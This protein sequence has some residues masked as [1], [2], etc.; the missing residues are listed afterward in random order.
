MKILITND[1]GISSPG[2]FAAK[3]AMESRGEVAVIAPD[4]N[5]SAIGRG[6]TIGRSLRVVET[7]FPDGSSGFAV[8]GTPVDCVR[9]AAL[10]FLQWHPDI[11]ISGIN[12]GPN[13]GDDIT[14]SGT[15]AA[16]FEGVML[17]IPA[18]AISI[19][20]GD[21]Y[22]FEPVARFTAGIAGMIRQNH[23]P[24]VILLNINSPNLPA[25]ELQGAEVT[26]LGKRIYRDQLVEE[27]AADGDGGGRSYTIYGDDPSYHEEDGTDFHA[28][29]QRKISVTPIHFALTNLT[30]MEII[31]NWD[32]DRLAREA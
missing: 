18:I 22:N 12:L 7:A 32:L 13:L 9:L 14:Y 15:V 21:S 1:D 25:A 28:L 8:D 4:R 30:G 2:L 6:I 26:R 10:G 29:N 20:G 16:A 19:E 11:V 27:P 3:Q 31:R 5:C 17:G 23:L 24:G